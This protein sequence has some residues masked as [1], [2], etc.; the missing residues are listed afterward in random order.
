M[1]SLVPMGELGSTSDDAHVALG[2]LAAQLELHTVFA[3]G[4]GAE[5]VA[6]GALEKGMPPSG[7]F[8]S[9][10]CEEA[11]EKLTRLL[12]AGDGVLVKGSRAAR[13]E[14]VVEALVLHMDPSGS[15]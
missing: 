13:M 1:I 4:E 3:V 9:E 12:M 7:V 11:S 14:R 8:V 5:G 15:H 2:R 10:S 6:A